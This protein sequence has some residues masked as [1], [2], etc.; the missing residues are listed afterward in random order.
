MN[1]F[2]WMGRNLKPEQYPYY[3]LSFG[4]FNRVDSE[5]ATPAGN[6]TRAISGGD[7]RLPG[8]S[9]EHLLDFAFKTNDSLLQK[10]AELG[11]TAK[12][13]PDVTRL[14]RVRTFAQE[15]VKKFQ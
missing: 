2:T 12:G 4:K 11:L 13:Q 14:K 1:F 6:E 15:I 10:L 3:R 7:I 5:A 8:R 9:P